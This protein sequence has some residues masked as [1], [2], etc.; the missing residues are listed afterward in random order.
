[1]RESGAKIAQVFSRY[2]CQ[3]FVILDHVV[4]RECRL[5]FLTRGSGTLLSCRKIGQWL[6]FVEPESVQAVACVGY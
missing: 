1:M 2:R 5:V 3:H 6:D 4:L